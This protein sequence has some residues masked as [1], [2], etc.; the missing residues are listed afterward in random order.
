VT[1]VK[2]N[3]A[4]RDGLAREAGEPGLAGW[5]VFVDY[6]NDAALDANE[7]RGVTNAAGAYQILGVVPGTFAVCEVGQAGWTCSYP[8]AGAGCAYT[9]A[10][11]SGQTTAGLNFGNFRP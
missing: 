9:R 3:D 1:E 4:D 6:D 2:F 5:T 8:G 11:G 10:L 7:P